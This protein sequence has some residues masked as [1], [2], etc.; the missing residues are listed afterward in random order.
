VPFSDYFT[1]QITTRKRA[2][3][4]P[5]DSFPIAIYFVT[6]PRCT[7]DALVSLLPKDPK[8]SPVHVPAVR[9]HL[10]L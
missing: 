10:L 4:F 2:G 1:I 6:D 9:T 7:R 3:I 5:P 8:G